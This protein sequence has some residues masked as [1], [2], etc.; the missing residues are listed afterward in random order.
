MS[1]NV[2]QSLAVGPAEAEGLSRITTVI[3]GTDDSISK[4]V[5]QLQ[6]LIDLREVRFRVP[7]L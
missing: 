1:G 5:Q 2:T 7:H 4:L 3:P 6:K